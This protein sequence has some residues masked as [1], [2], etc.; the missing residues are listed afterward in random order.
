MR[1]SVG[2]NLGNF[3]RELPKFFQNKDA[4]ITELIQ[5]SYRAGATAIDITCTKKVFKIIDN[6][7]GIKD[8]RD[9]FTI[10]QSGW[11]KEGVS[12]LDPAGMG[13]FSAFLTADRVEVDTW[14]TENN[15][16]I[17]KYASFTK[18]QILA[19]HPI[20]VGDRA[21]DT[22]ATANGT[23]ITLFNSFN[24]EIVRKGCVDCGE[25]LIENIEGNPLT[26]KFNDASIQQLDYLA[27]PSTVL[28]KT[29]VSAGE[30][31]FVESEGDTNNTALFCGQIIRFRDFETI[32]HFRLKVKPGGLTL[33][34]PDRTEF[35]KDEKYDT[36]IREF[37]VVMKEYVWSQK[38]ISLQAA[39]KYFSDKKAVLVPNLIHS[40]DIDYDTLAL[41]T[42]YDTGGMHKAELSKETASQ[43]ALISL[44]IIISDD[45]DMDDAH[46]IK[47]LSAM[48]YIKANIGV[49]NNHVFGFSEHPEFL[50][51]KR[52]L[53]DFEINIK[54][55][56][57]EIKKK[58]GYDSF[59]RAEITLKDKKTGK[60]YPVK[61]LVLESE[62]F[63][64]GATFYWSFDEEL[65]GKNQDKI[66][67]E[68]YRVCQL[69]YRHVGDDENRDDPYDDDFSSEYRSTIKDIFAPF[70]TLAR[71]IIGEIEGTIKTRFKDKML[72]DIVVADI[73]I[74]GDKVLFTVKN[75]KYKY[76][77]DGQEIKRT[78][79]A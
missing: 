4:F 74:R 59:F 36:F 58:G 27:A 55:K 47:V 45:Y 5:N 64:D 34:L 50:K 16:K 25:Y 30:L 40:F 3:V 46:H 61:G 38:M 78:K 79:N 44:D 18:E 65:T 41:Q 66:E 8:M 14:R 23:A 56:G 21:E 39:E 32:K 29:S 77:F 76:V 2:L 53:E 7:H 68:A 33:R 20:Y 9:I 48:D 35:V 60:R 31:V 17:V 62:G 51:R 72:D 6:G 13:I 43:D 73:K 11:E 71:D 1:I 15:K 37:E 75:K 28:F 54:K 67:S 70:G 26:I 22:F 57:K 12:Q 24:I 49:C 19:G 10:A 42:Y 63:Y 69:I 52:T